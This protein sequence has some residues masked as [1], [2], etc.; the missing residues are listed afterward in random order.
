MIDS[1]FD[2]EPNHPL[3]DRSSSLK[4][5]Y[6]ATESSI[7]SCSQQNGNRSIALPIFAEATAQAAR[8]IDAPIS[9]LMTSTVSGYSIAAFAGLER[10]TQLSLDPD[11]HTE[12]AGL[13]YCHTQTIGGSGKF[14][15]ANLRD[16][17]LLSQSALHRIHGIRAY[18]GIPMMTAARDLLGTLAIL[19]FSPRQ[20]CDREIEILYSIG[21]WSASEFERKCLSQAQL[22]RWVGELRSADLTVRGF[23]DARAVAERELAVSERPPA[24]LGTR[25]ARYEDRASA[26]SLQPAVAALQPDYLADPQ[27]QNQL[28]FRLLTH[29]AQE[30]RTPLTAVLG[31]VSV[32]QQE[33]Y[34]TLNG[35]QKDYLEIVHHSSER[36]VT[37]VNEISELGEFVGVAAPS[38][39]HQQTKLSLRAVDLEMLCRL[40]LQSLESP[41]QKKHHQIEIEQIG[42]HS[43]A[44]AAN[45]RI[46]LVDKDKVRQIIYYLTLSVIHATS[47]YHRISIHTANLPEGLQFQIFTSDDLAVLPDLQPIDRLVSPADEAERDRLLTANIGQDL[48]IRLGLSLSQTLASADGGKIELLADGRGYRATYPI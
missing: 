22:N 38:A 47:P 1:D 35:K 45:E 23:D 17:L 15:V 25:R 8:L 44:D 40:A 30:L 2:L 6:L 46:W 13:E 41:I 31:M 26:S 3:I 28:Q 48:R 29:L 18:L 34:G 27:L 7:D 24:E 42:E 4:D 16:D 5:R 14:V 10:L 36:L 11:L 43:T 37:I 39:S 9:I 33:I 20:F 12:L 32:L 21:R 19:D